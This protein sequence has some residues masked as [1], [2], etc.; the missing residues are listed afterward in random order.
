MSDEMRPSEQEP[1]IQVRDLQFGW[2]REQV[3]KG[4]YLEV[5]RGEAMA[6]VGANGA[7]KSTLLG[8]LSGAEPY[9]ARWRKP[10]SF[11]R[12]L[13]LD[14]VRDGHRLRGS[15][16][17]VPDRIDL[18]KWMRIRDHFR[19]VRAIYPL[20]NDDEAKRWLDKFELDPALRYADLSKGQRMLENLT[21]ALALRPPLLLLDEPFSGLDPVARHMVTDCVIEHMCKEGGTVLLVSHSITDIER[22][23]DRVAMFAHGRVTAVQTVDDLRASNSSHDLEAALVAAAAEGRAA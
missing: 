22:C 6:L 10:R 3:L 8:L 23:A 14:P 18:P 1:A 15:I 11:V 21:T 9:R 2:T 7:G 13:G 4:V 17:Y 20:W 5:R 12:V 19:L 16:G